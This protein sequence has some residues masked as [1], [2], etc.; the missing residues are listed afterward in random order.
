MRREATE[1][2]V[3][4]GGPAGLAAAEAA[5]TAGR[6]VCMLDDNPALGGQIWRRDTQKAQA[7]GNQNVDR[8]RAALLEA[9]VDIRSGTAVVD[10]HGRDALWAYDGEEL[11]QW[12]TEHV[13]LATGARERTLPFPGWTRPG[14]FG[15]G[16]LQALTKAGL[17]VEGSRVVVAGTG[18]LLL[19]VATS[20]QQ[21]GAQVLGV[22]EQASHARFVRFGLGLWSQPA[23][24][25][26]G[27]AFGARLPLRLGSWIARADG[28]PELSSVVVRNARGRER[29]IECDLVACGFGLVPETRLARLLGARVDDA[30]I[31]DELQRTD[32]AGVLAAGEPCGVGGEDKALCEGTI[33]GLVAAGREDEA[34]P[35]LAQRDRYRA[36]AA[37]MARDFALRDELRELP[38]PDTLVCRCEDV[39]LRALT[40]FDRARAAKLGSRCGMGPCQGRVCQPAIRFLLGHGHDRPRPPLVPLPLGVM[41]E[42]QS[43][44][45][46]SSS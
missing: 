17:D 25:L 28:N 20:L 11:T 31:V 41:A 16:G 7:P 34:R 14:V 8:R 29:T 4:G 6:K 36:F 35:L 45:Q 24:L 40:G 33:A 37:R 39:P 30:V 42:L 38:D 44:S 5:A 46:G 23:K 2:L 21:R 18:P 26:Q 9:G 15:A 32:A 22:F 3:V 1:V 27:M 19:A 43:T 13:I 12:Q 10:A